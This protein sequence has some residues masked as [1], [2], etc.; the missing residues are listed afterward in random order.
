MPQYT[1]GPSSA[2]FYELILDES[3][4]EVMEKAIET[5]EDLLRSLLFTASLSLNPLLIPAVT[6]T[7]A[8]LILLKKAL[9]IA[10]LQLV[11]IRAG[12]R[13][14]FGSLWH[15]R[16]RAI[17]VYFDDGSNYTYG[18]GAI[19]EQM[20]VLAERNSGLVRFI[21]SFVKFGYADSG[22]G[23][24]GH[25]VIGDIGNILSSQSST[26]RR[27]NRLATANRV[28]LPNESRGSA[29]LGF[30]TQVAQGDVFD[31]SD[32]D[33]PAINI[34]AEET[35]GKIRVLE[36]VELALG[37]GSVFDPERT[38]EEIETA[39]INLERGVTGYYNELVFDGENTNAPGVQNINAS[40]SQ[41]IDL[42][43][44]GNRPFN[45]GDFDVKDTVIGLATGDDTPDA[46]AVQGTGFLGHLVVGLTRAIFGSVREEYGRNFQHAQQRLAVSAELKG[47]IPLYNQN[48]KLVGVLRAREL[49]EI[50]FG[51]AR[52]LG[53]G[54]SGG[55][56][57]RDA[58]VYQFE[59][60][61]GEGRTYLT[62]DEALGYLSRGFQGTQDLLSRV[63]SSALAYFNTPQS[64]R[65]RLPPGSEHLRRF[66][67]T[68]PFG[69]PVAGSPVEGYPSPKRTFQ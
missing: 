43:N 29:N 5:A 33:I 31:A 48:D 47:D 55:R 62:R 68:R 44:S 58:I 69:S 35:G 9:V 60:I 2:N 67:Y 28:L 59:D 20:T 26:R 19:A 24:R 45:T 27:S 18:P 30:D 38:V 54:R 1:S 40:F 51:V 17:V 57:T 25:G 15:G 53:V 14:Y 37:S 65:D 34:A 36:G 63:G 32:V 49:N 13:S 42:V 23:V 6:S 46:V 64:V 66:D 4:F 10:Q 61:L 39:S 11:Q 3:L 21:H 22:G 52:V 56:P 16:L 12:A 50:P 7:I 8:L 41:Y